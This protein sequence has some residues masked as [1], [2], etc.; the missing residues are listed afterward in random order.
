[1]FPKKISQ[2]VDIFARIHGNVFPWQPAIMGNKASFYQSIF[3]IS[4]PSLHLSFHNACPRYL[5]SRRN[6]LYTNLQASGTADPEMLLRLVI[7][8]ASV[9]GKRMKCKMC[10]VLFKN[11]EYCWLSCGQGAYL[12]MTAKGAKSLQNIL[13]ENCSKFDFEQCA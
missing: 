13:W 7:M 5:K 3:Q 11:Q 8:G 1:M 6:L 9:I 10:N 2:N 4:L 12:S